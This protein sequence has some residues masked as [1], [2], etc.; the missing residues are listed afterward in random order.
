MYIRKAIADGLWLRPCSN[1]GLRASRRLIC[2]PHAGGTAHTYRT[3]PAYLPLD[4]GVY[5]VQYPGRQDRYGEPPADAIE[6]M[7]DEIA[8]AVEPFTGDPL[9]IFGHSMGAY[10]AYEVTAA[11]E[12]R[13]GP[14]VDL[15]VVSGV[16]APHH[17]SPSEVHRLGDPEFAAEVARD[18]ASFGELLASPDLVQVLLPMIRDD[19]RLF[20]RYQPGDPPV[21]HTR[22]LATG[23]TEDPDVDHAGLTLWG[24]LTGGGFEAL[25]FSGGHSYLVDDEPAL[26]N[27]IAERLPAA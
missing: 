8:S 16:I 9:V 26:V 17:K 27:S 11:L 14:V 15:L 1:P 2:L 12:R 10:V 23:G 3:W 21:L 18:N 19:Y 20:E 24:E 6:D 4:L 5:S 7:A 13:H 25:S 22:V